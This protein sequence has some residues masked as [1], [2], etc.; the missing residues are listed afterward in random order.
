[1]SDVTD[2]GAPRERPSG[3][4]LDSWKEIASYLDR[5]V[6][7]VKRWEAVEGLPVRR[8]QHQHSSSV[9]AY[10][11]ELDAW[12][13]ARQPRR[14]SGGCTR[15]ETAVS[16]EAR[17]SDRSMRWAASL[18]AI[19]SAAIILIG[20]AYFV[21]QHAGSS[22]AQPAMRLAVLPMVNLNGDPR[23]EYVSDSLTEDMIAELGASEPTRLSIVA[24]TSAM[25]YKHTEKRV[26]EI[27]RE[28]DVDY[29]LESSVRRDEGRIR[30]TAQLIDARTQRHVWTQQYERE[31]R[32]VSSVHA[33]VIR[34]IGR[35]VSTR[36]V[37]GRGE[38]PRRVFEHRP[39]DPEAFHLYLRGLY[40]Y[41]KR[42]ALGFRNALGHFTAATERDPAYARAYAGMADTYAVM[43]SYGL[44]PIS[45]SHPR[46]RAAALRALEIDDTLAEAHAALGMITSDYYWDWTEAERRFRLAIELNPSYATAYHWY[47]FYLGNMGRFDEALAA[48]RRAQDLDPLSLAANANVGLVYFRGRRNDEAITQ[49]RRTLDLNPQFGYAH[50]CLGLAYAQNGMTEQ[51][52]SEFQ[53]AKALSDL[54]NTDALLAY[55]WARSGHKRE[56][57]TIA[58]SL[59]GGAAHSGGANYHNALVHAA[60]GD[61]DGAFLWL[62]RAVDRREWFASMFKG[63]PLLDPL[64]SDSRFG[65]LLL[66][67]GLT[68]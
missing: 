50:L 18:A 67:I 47:S 11:S 14:L 62:N 12:T 29:V 49:L 10:K 20:V 19:G 42:T 45:D 36:L 58:A 37:D 9:W 51:A 15:T 46:G 23:E 61:R 41:N 7:T 21:F 57:E 43:G 8:H 60:L 25:H 33:D 44:M 27:A 56:A 13:L 55:A 39:R 63:D 38:A 66:R 26:D 52:I 1:V 2:W 5:S 4:R 35:A 3:E 64:R 34:A 59:Q 28:L 22:S 54:P 53:M 16:G 32:D 30:I 68:P 31:A 48:A 40:E 6:R 65:A 24:R 17:A